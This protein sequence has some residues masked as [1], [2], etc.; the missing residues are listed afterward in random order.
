MKDFC[1]EV[2]LFCYTSNMNIIDSLPDPFNKIV[3]EN[4]VGSYKDFGVKNPEDYPLAG[5]NFF[6]DYGY[7]PGY[8]GEDG[9]EL[10]FFVGSDSNGQHGFFTVWRSKEVP[11]EHKFFLALNEEQLK[12]T[13]KEY[14]PVF[15][16]QVGLASLNEVATVINEFKNT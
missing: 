4:E 2:F 7:L 12:K 15:V 13:V 10:D 11:Q 14:S 8:T 5:V 3:I 6:A 16:R 1:R 9:H